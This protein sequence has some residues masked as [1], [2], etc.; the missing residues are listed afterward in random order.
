MNIIQ[1]LKRI[2]YGLS[3]LALSAAAL[4]PALMATPASALGLVTSRSI[5]MSS[6]LQAATGVIYHVSF[7]VATTTSIGGVVV[8]FCD[9]SPV[10]GT[11]CTNAN[12]FDTSSATLA[13]LSGLSG[14]TKDAAT[15]ANTFII[16]NG[17][18]QAKTS[19]NT[20]SF[21]ING[22]T[23]PNTTNTT[24]YA[25]IVTYDTAAHAQAYTS[26]AT[27]GGTGAV[28]HGGIALSTAN[29]ITAGN[30]VTIV[31]GVEETLTFCV[32]TGANCAAGGS[33]VTL[34][35]VNG[36]LS[37]SQ[38][39]TDNSTTF[40]LASNAIGGTFVR[41]KGGTLKLT[42][43]CPDGTGQNC[44]INPIGGTQAGST[45]GIEQF[46]MKL[47]SS[48]APL[49]ATAPYNSASNY[50]FDDN[51]TDGTQ[52]T[53]GDEIASMGPGTVQTGTMTFMAN[54]ASTTEAGIYSTALTFI[55]TGIY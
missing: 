2:P 34:G 42:P 43:A 18:P 40:D 38:V 1:Q 29:G 16:T 15:D 31:T 21:D 5:M 17:T 33:S 36:V 10:I 48:G 37:P 7:N 30:G 3:A 32:Y 54:I 13:N 20:I 45:T 9:T 52:S 11:S 14:F 6:S 26:T 49:A 19:G 50:A 25:R 28:D 46:G 51:S 35:D 23:N 53:Y 4:I 47:A 22:V 55:A 27:D 8:D 41:M 39:Y 12:S 24:F 44:S